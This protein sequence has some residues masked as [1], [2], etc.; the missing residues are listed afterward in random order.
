MGGDVQLLPL[1]IRKEWCHWNYLHQKKTLNK[2]R[3]Y[4]EENNN[5][6]IRMYIREKKKL[7]NMFNCG[8]LD[9]L[10]WVLSLQVRDDST[11]MGSTIL[12]VC[13]TYGDDGVHECELFSCI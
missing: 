4:F 7:T 9:L 6:K 11:K 5:N 10:M 1:I 13:F 2:L 12:S 8:S 3:D